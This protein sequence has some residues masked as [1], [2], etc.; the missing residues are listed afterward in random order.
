MTKNTTGGSK[1]KKLSKTSQNTKADLHDI[2]YGQ[3]VGRVIKNLG[4][5]RMLVYCNDNIQRI[6]RIRGALRKRTWISVGNIVLISLRTMVGWEEDHSDDDID[7]ADNKGDI[8][9][10][11]EPE[12][13]S[14][15]KKN[16]EVNKR[17]FLQLEHLD[18]AV[19]AGGIGLLD[20]AKMAAIHDE[21][22]EEEDDD[23]DDEEEDDKKEGDRGKK[24]TRPGVKAPEEIDVDAI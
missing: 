6:C 22:F 12:V 2:S 23:D 14:K 5:K 15:L 18:A 19:L 11:Y 9:A 13:H 21:W 4:T 10:K 7:K 8:L 24:W 20:E 3:Q 1:H 17:L 16:R